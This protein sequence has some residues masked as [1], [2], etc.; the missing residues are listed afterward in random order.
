MKIMITARG[1]SLDSPVDERFG[2]AEVF[3]IYDSDAKQVEAVKNPFLNNQ[4]GV[5]IS[6][7][8][9]AVEK[10]VDALVSGSFGP[11]A[12]EI[13]RASSIKLY[14]AQNGNVQENVDKL[15]SGKLEEF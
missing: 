4:G 15:L 5:G 1:D 13:L 3:L 6:A 14:K 9:F 8:K 12:L 2:R 11:N 7:A 10:G